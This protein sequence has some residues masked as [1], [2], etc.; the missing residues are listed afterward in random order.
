MVA[1]SGCGEDAVMRLLALLVVLVPVLLVR[2]GTASADDPPGVDARD[3]VYAEPIDFPPDTV[4]IIETGCSHC[5]APNQGYYRVYRLSSGPVH[6]E[7]IIVEHSGPFEI[8]GLIA[9]PDGAFMLAWKCLDR[10]G[11]GV[12]FSLRRYHWS[13]DGGV[14]WTLLGE[15]DDAYLPFGTTPDGPVFAN[16]S[17]GTET[18]RFFD[19]TPLSEAQLHTYAGFPWYTTREW[20]STTKALRSPDGT[21]IAVLPYA[22]DRPFL[23]WRLGRTPVLSWFPHLARGVQ[24]PFYY[25]FTMTAEDGTQ[26]G[27]RT[28]PFSGLWEWLDDRFIVGSFDP[29]GNISPGMFVGLLDLQEGVVYPIGAPFGERPLVGR[30]F[31]KLALRGPFLRVATAECLP[32]RAWAD[33]FASVT[34]CAA[35]GVLLRPTGGL[36]YEHGVDWREA[37]MPNG[38]TGWV[39]RSGVEG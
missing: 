17:D 4:F 36:R 11:L 23:L 10:C 18:P 31:V 7:P 37:S 28:K 27:V 5:D 9:S 2:V 24:E 35:P 22:G 20:D 1:A 6:V 39:P 29:P 26:A 3:L 8:T 32:L 25:Y 33:A 13:D 21:P 16:L 34:A 15:R 14:T 30:N 19:G 12:A 38:T